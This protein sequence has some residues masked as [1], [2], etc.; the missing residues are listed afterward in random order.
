M[1]ISEQEE[2]LIVKFLNDNLSAEELSE[3]NALKE[4]KKA[5]TFKNELNAYKELHASLKAHNKVLFK[6]EIKDVF[7]EMEKRNKT[8]KKSKI[9]YLNYYLAAGVAAAVVLFMVFFVPNWLEGNQLTNE[10]LFAKYYKVLPVGNTVGIEVEGAVGIKLYKEGAYQEAKAPLRQL[11]EEGEYKIAAIYLGISF[12][13]LGDLKGASDQFTEVI[14]N[15]NDPFY[16]QYARWYLAL[17]A[18]KN[19]ENDNAKLLL[20]TII[21]NDELYKQE[22]DKLLNS[23]H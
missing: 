20:Q 14:T 16:Q 3:F 17:I 7:A 1:P 9:V 10:Q 4:G 15:P 12:M 6:E 11:E 23:L 18:L 8:E 5:S 13:E 22:A 21:E 2:E 19:R